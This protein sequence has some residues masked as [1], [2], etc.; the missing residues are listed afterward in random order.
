M[1][2]VL[3][4]S[5]HGTVFHLLPPATLPDRLAQLDLQSAWQLEHEQ[6]WLMG[7]AYTGACM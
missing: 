4:M 7:L 2:R 3:Y 6:L 5:V 1:M